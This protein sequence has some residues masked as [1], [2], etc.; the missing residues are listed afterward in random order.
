MRPD[1]IRPC[2]GDVLPVRGCLAAMSYMLDGDWLDGDE[3]AA[4]LAQEDFDCWYMDWLSWQWDAAYEA[5][6]DDQSRWDA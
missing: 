2:G 3:E 5:S 6:V 1:L 4:Y